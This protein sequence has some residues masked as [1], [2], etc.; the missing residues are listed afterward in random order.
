MFR[1]RVSSS[2]KDVDVQRQEGLHLLPSLSR[3]RV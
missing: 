2:H 3:N 1:E